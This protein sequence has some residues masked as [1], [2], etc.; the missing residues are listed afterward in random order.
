MTRAALLPSVYIYLHALL[1]APVAPLAHWSGLDVIDQPGDGQWRD[2][3]PHRVPQG[4]HGGGGD[5]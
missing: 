2:A 5:A 1:A 4:P 3:A